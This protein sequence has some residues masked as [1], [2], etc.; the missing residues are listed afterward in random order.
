MTLLYR[1]RVISTAA[2]VVWGESGGT[3]MGL[4]V[5]KTLSLDALANGSSR[6]GASHD[7]GAD[8][9][10]EW[11]AILCVET[12]TAPTAGNAA[13]AYMS[14]SID[15]STWPGKVTGS[16]AAYPTTVVDNLK[17]LGV[18]IT[19]LLTSNDSNTVLQQ[20]GQIYTP[21]SRYIAPV[22]YNAMGQAFR[23]EV[24]ASNN[25]SGLIL[26][27]AKEYYSDTEP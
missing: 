4:S 24:T 20:L 6:M 7:L 19:S 26:V 13:H 5:T 17:Q 11:I 21:L 14:E 18:P 8:W 10:Q 16:D 27:P 2:A 25:G 1:G 3:I 9:H 23:D 22:I 15:G 12:G